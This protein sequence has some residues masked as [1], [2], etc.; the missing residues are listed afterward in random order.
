MTKKFNTRLNALKALLFWS[1]RLLAI[2]FL[3][4]WI[5]FTDQLE[6]LKDH[7]AAIASRF[8]G[9][10]KSKL[11]SASVVAIKALLM[12]MKFTGMLRG[13]KT[14]L[15]SI[16]TRFLFRIKSKLPSASVV[17]IRALLVWIKFTGILR[18]LKTYLS[19]IFPRLLAR[20]KR[21]S[22]RD[23]FKSFLSRYF[24]YLVLINAVPLLALAWI[25]FGT[26]VVPASVHSTHS[27]SWWIIFQWVVIV[28]SA[29]HGVFSIVLLRMRRITQ[30]YILSLFVTCSP[31]LYAYVG[32]ARQV[33]GFSVSGTLNAF[34]PFLI[35]Y[36]KIILGMIVLK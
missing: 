34:I 31:F 6:K 36:S 35:A 1:I 17:A 27:S 33:N 28:L 12:W 11:P 20:L 13:L 18:G 26:L 32:Y 8:I 19:S 9:R 25:Y 4:L 15:S 3:L 29:V 24:L 5:K 22:L 2:H 7:G 30:G 10:I 21:I 16:F 14:Y 23:F